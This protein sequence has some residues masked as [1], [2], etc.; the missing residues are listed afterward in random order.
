AGKDAAAAAERNRDI[1]AC[2]EERGFRLEAGNPACL[3][4]STDTACYGRKYG[5]EYG[6]G[7]HG[8]RVRRN[9]AAS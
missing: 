7:C 1:D 3:K 9:I 6:M 5:S 8:A 4:G 2:M